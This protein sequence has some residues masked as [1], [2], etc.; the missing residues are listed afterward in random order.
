MKAKPVYLAVSVLSDW[1]QST[2]LWSP[3]RCGTWCVASYNRRTLA[4]SLVIAGS[5]FHGVANMYD[6]SALRKHHVGLFGMYLFQLI[7]TFLIS[8]KIVLIKFKILI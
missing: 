1:I 3:S 5:V 8:L 2:T 4:R 7:R 6:I